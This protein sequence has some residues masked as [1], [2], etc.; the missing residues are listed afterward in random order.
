MFTHSSRRRLGTLAAGGA[1]L[2]AGASGVLTAAPAHAATAPASAAKVVKLTQA[3]AAHRLRAAGIKWWS[4]G[5]CTTRSNP[6]CTSFEKI[7]KSTVQGIIAFKKAGRCAITITGGTEVGHATMK[8]S[9]HNGYKLDIVPTGCVSRYIR[10]KFTY[11]GHRGDG[12]PQWKA[13]SGNLYCNEGSHW[14]ITYFR[15]KA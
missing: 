5:H 12:Y 1:V 15:G 8:Y 7:N 9:H 10:A 13:P 6:Q 3:Q 4:Q 11:I 14:D 2:V